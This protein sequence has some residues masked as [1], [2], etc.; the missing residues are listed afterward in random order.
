[1][2]D[3]TVRGRRER[4]GRCKTCGLPPDDGHLY[5]TVGGF[6]LVMTAG[7]LVGALLTLAL[8]T[9]LDWL[10]PPGIVS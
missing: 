4:E 2:D 5:T 10:I 3:R 8:I 7:A 1:V 9:F 6:I